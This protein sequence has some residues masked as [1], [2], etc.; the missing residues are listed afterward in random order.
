MAD[1]PAMDEED[2]SLKT[3]DSIEIV[4]LQERAD[5]LRY[6][7]I[8][9]LVRHIPMLNFSEKI[10][11]LAVTEETSYSQ[12][13]ENDEETD[14]VIENKDKLEEEEEKKSVEESLQKVESILMEI[15][16]ELGSNVDENG[17]SSLSDEPNSDKKTLRY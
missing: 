16:K 7:Y 14:T 13:D 5:K 1:W 8:H 15:D 17:L 3:N 2:E 11:E 10:K 4:E 12:F 9:G 6:F